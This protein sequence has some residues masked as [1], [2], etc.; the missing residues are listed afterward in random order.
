MSKNKSF[1]KRLQK[2]II[3]RAMTYLATPE[4][5]ATFTKIMKRKKQA[6]R[7]MA[8]LLKTLGLASLRDKQQ[9]EWAIERQGR[10]LRDLTGSLAE[11]ESALTRLENALDKPIA[12]PP[13]APAPEKAV[14]ARPEPKVVDL[15]AARRAKAKRRTAAKKTADAKPRPAAKIKETPADPKP[16]A[17]KP[18][19][20]KPVI[21]KDE[22]PKTA[23]KTKKS[24]APAGLGAT[25][26]NKDRRKEL[27]D[28]RFRK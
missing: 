17:K 9:V 21:Q 25:G 14:V 6:D 28:L 24:A 23:A 1:G 20:K 13:A 19:S 3:K 8:E 16:A 10:R 12:E 22:A 5:M 18:E 2:T 11:V 4:G 7:A 27:L 15:G 26:G